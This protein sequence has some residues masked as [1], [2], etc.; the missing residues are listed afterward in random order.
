MSSFSCEVAWGRFV[1]FRGRQDRKDLVPFRKF[2][3]P[4]ADCF[5]FV[6]RGG[7]S[8][9]DFCIGP[10]MLLGMGSSTRRVLWFG[11]IFL[12]VLLLVGVVAKLASGPR[13]Q[14]KG[15]E[16]WMQRTEDEN[17][18]NFEREEARL[19]VRHMA[20]NN[21]PVLLKWFR[22]ADQDASEPA[23][24]DF[25]NKILSHQNLLAIQVHATYRASRPRVAEAI[26]AEY[27]EVA[28]PVLPEFVSALT[29]KVLQKQWNASAV[30][31]KIGEPAIQ[32]LMP[33]LAHR[34][35]EG[36]YMAVMTL[37]EIGLHERELRPRFYALTCD[38]SVDVRL[39]AA[40]A[41]NKLGEDSDHTMPVI[42]QCYREGNLAT[43]QQALEALS[44][45]QSRAR[46]ALPF[47]TNTLAT[48]TNQM[49][50]QRM[51]Y[52]LRA[53]VPREQ[54]TNRQWAGPYE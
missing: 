5:L 43:R 15:L 48:L 46:P 23:Y 47:L 9:L 27:P 35:D 19:A 11:A 38:S 21:L 42:L 6:D 54:A 18:R 40:R 8:A 29:N 53:I 28:V 44:E 26:F 22:E 20:T 52:V 17:L 31:V 1:Y 41:L 2:P 25:I 12:A 4:S 33:L 16:E 39:A 14:G 37:G 32:P 7:A 13:Y 24:V 45:L 34:S 36:R 49:E 10:A 30:L 3:H 50:K 51:I